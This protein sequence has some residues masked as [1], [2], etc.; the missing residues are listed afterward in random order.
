MMHERL[1][2]AL[3][4]SLLLVSGRASAATNEMEKPPAV[5]HFYSVEAVM[6]A[7]GPTAR[8]KLQSVFAQQNVLYPPKQMTWI[9]LKEERMLL[10]FARDKNGAM[11]KVLTYPMI[12]ASGVAGPKLKEGDKQVPEGF[13][14]IAAFR[15]TLVAHIGLEVNY[16]NNSDRYH[17]RMEKRK[18]PGSDILIHGSKW[19]TGCL[20]MGNKPIEEM[21][22]LAHETGSEHINLIF[23][24]CDLRLKKPQ[25][26]FKTQP[27]WLPELYSDLEA[28]LSKYPI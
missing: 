13:Y 28:Q 20:A 14:S 15:P 8:K 25:V 11:R 17:A 16:P 5:P 2:C 3:A 4:F 10:L 23:A 12:G 1:L 21:F 24:P 26:N 27:K 22:V 19:S 6:A 7:Y 18:N 9:A